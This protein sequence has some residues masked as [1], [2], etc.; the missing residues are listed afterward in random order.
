MMRTK[1]YVAVDPRTGLTIQLSLGEGDAEIHEEG[2]WVPFL[3][4][5]HGRLV[6]ESR[7]EFDDPANPS[8]LKLVVVAQELGAVLGTDAADEALLW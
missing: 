3:R 6:T 2:R 7:D 4:W 1:P 8:R 5:Q